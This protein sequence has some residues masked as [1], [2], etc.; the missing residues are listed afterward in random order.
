M[1]RASCLVLSVLVVLLSL[2][3]QENDGF[4]SVQ[5]EAPLIVSAKNAQFVGRLISDRNVDVSNHGFWLATDAG[6]SDKTVI[7]LGQRTQPGRYLG[8]T[9]VLVAGG[10]YFVKSFFVMG[11]DTFFGNVIQFQALTPGIQSFAPENAFAGEE[12]SILGYNLAA[13]TRVFFGN[14]EAQILSNTFESRLI[15]K[16]PPIVDN[17]SPRI[18]VQTLGQELVF[19]LPFQYIIGK[20]IRF[21]FPIRDRLVNSISFKKGNQLVVLSGQTTEFDINSK[22]WTFDLLQKT[23]KENDF[24]LEPHLYGFGADGFFGGGLSRIPSSNQQF[25]NRTFWKMEGD[26]F[27]KLPDVPFPSVNSLCFMIGTKLYVMGG[28]IEG[29]TNRVFMFD[30][31]AE[32]WNEKNVFPFSID[33]RVPY[34]TDGDEVM[35]VRDNKEVTA[36]NPETGLRRILGRWPSDNSQEFGIACKLGRKA[37]IGFYRQTIEVWELDLDTY[38]WKRKSNFPGIFLGNNLGLFEDGQSYWLLRST[39]QFTLAEGNMEFWKFEPE[40]F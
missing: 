4:I 39:D 6:F 8:S 22:Y 17:S 27:R 36:Y 33:N 25:L 23:W 31:I 11:T 9:D 34:F 12:I 1:L 37:L 26:N 28:S 14:Q 5:T 2:S 18:R 24:G 30:T 16:A 32:T 7:S 40:G 38:R 21:G 20:F 29:E 13:G 15:V 10:T 19:D 35:F 3:C